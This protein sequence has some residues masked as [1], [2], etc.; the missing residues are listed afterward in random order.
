MVLSKF[1][2]LAASV[3]RLATLNSNQAFLPYTDAVADMLLEKSI[4]VLAV[5]ESNVGIPSLAGLRRRM[6]R[7]GYNVYHQPG[8]N[9]RGQVTLISKTPFQQGAPPGVCWTYPER[10][11]AGRLYR[12]GMEPILFANIYGH[13]QDRGSRE[14]LIKEVAAA[15][16]ATGLQWIIIGDFNEV[17]SEGAVAYLQANGIA[18]AWDTDFRVDVGPT[19]HPGSRTI[20]Y[21]ISSR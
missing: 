2:A 18:N 4:D 5:Q 19:R 8:A 20:D 10:V 16:H 3:L 15:F 21:A 7:D 13:V 1:V 9:D 11:L 12:S 6:K 14:R 17:D